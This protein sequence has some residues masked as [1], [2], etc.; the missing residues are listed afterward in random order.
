M[1]L[2]LQFLLVSVSVKITSLVDC[3]L[4]VSLVIMILNHHMAL[5]VFLVTVTS[6]VP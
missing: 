6:E 3:V 4:S 5:D 1:I 2:I